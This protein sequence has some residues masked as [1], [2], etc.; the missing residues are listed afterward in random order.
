MKKNQKEDSNR[1]LYI[2]KSTK[3][4]HSD[5]KTI[6][7]KLKGSIQDF[8]FEFLEIYFKKVLDKKVTYT[9]SQ[10]KDILCDRIFHTLSMAFI[11]KQTLFST[12]ID[13]IEE[14]N[15]WE[16]LNFLLEVHYSSKP[17]ELPDIL[18]E[19]KM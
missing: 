10:K 8:K 19:L 16:N 7:E 9:D 1:I 12:T 6:T 3:S 13:I 14:E 18:S 11:E 15:Y 5:V 17:I 4:K 2:F